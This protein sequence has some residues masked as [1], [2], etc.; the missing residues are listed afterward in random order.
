MLKLGVGILMASSLQKKFDLKKCPYK[1]LQNATNLLTFDTAFSRLLAVIGF[2]R[3]SCICLHLS[4][5]TSCIVHLVVSV[6]MSIREACGDRIVDRIQIS[7][8]KTKTKPKTKSKNQ[9]RT[10]M[11]R[12]QRVAFVPTVPTDAGA[13]P[14]RGRSP[15]WAGHGGAGRSCLGRD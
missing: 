8:L 11:A 6:V 12:G 14:Y 4:L 9:L 7:E 2:K 15:R 13:S 1:C 3:R 5:F 10:S